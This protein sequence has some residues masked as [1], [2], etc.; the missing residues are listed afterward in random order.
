MAN[1][2]NQQQLVEFRQTLN[3]YT[4][5]WCSPKKKVGNK[6]VLVKNI[7]YLVTGKDGIGFALWRLRETMSKLKCTTHNQSV[8]RCAKVSKT[9]R[10]VYDIYSFKCKRINH[11]ISG[12]M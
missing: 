2:V 11:S 10:G 7:N 8:W 6:W 5:Q 4:K 9:K 12:V 3:T 1:Q